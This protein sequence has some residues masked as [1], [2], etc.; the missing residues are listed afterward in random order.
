MND[1]KSQHWLAVKDDLDKF[2][3][4]N[5]ASDPEYAIAR[6]LLDLGEAVAS[7]TFPSQ[8]QF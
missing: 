1:P 4:R 6:Q 5:L 7:H 3:Q 8:E 2:H